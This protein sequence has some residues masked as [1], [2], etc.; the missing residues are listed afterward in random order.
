MAMG[1][2]QPI[3]F[4][5]NFQPSASVT[6][7]AFQPIAFQINFQQSAPAPSEVVSDFHRRY[8]RTSYR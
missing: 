3:A 5:V 6:L 8:R 7:G 2:F 4:Q 1:A